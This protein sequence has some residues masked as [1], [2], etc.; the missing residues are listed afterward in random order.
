MYSGTVSISALMKKLNTP[1]PTK[2]L[3]EAD[4]ATVR[5]VLLREWCAT[6]FVTNT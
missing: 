6:D 3:R 4:N 2:A 1:T 5:S